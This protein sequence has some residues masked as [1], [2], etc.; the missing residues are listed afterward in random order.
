MLNDNIYIAAP[1]R[2]REQMPAIAT[3]LE[4]AGFHITHK[5]WLVDDVGHDDEDHITTNAEHAT[6]DIEGV[7]NAD[8]VLLINTGKS[9]GKAIEQG[10][11]LAAGLPI[12]AVGKRGE[13]SSN[14]FHY[15]PDY[16][17][18]STLDEAI[19]CLKKL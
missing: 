5:W 16:K 8:V 2:D 4:D 6:K 19:E 10:V 9:E 11:A 13:H 3:Q 17:W 12:V 1:F 14:L 18:V 7:L 15:L